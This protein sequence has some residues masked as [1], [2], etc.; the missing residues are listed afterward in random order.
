MKRK[1][2]AK[3][4]PTA[5]GVS[6]EGEEAAMSEGSTR[7]SVARKRLS[8]RGLGNERCVSDPP[9]SPAAT[10]LPWEAVSSLGRATLLL[11][12]P[13]ALDGG[14]PVRLTIDPKAERCKHPV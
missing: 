13:R 12:C 10:V 2:C 1:C 5:I 8:G 11:N 9:A 3:P 4:P 7:S 6:Q 14:G